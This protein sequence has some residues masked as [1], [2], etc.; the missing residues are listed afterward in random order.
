MAEAVDPL[1]VADAA[2]E[3]ILARQ[4]IEVECHLRDQA[5]RHLADLLGMTERDSRT[6]VLGDLIFELGRLGEICNC[7]ITRADLTLP[8]T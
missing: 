7:K 4:R 1:L 2:L 3:V 8:P 5:V 6:I